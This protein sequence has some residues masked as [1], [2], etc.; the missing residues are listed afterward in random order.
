MTL[1]TRKFS[2]TFYHHYTVAR[3][4]EPAERDAVVIYVFI[5]SFELVRSNRPMT[6]TLHMNVTICNK[7]YTCIKTTCT[8]KNRTYLRIVWETYE[9][10]EMCAQMVNVKKRALCVV[11]RSAYPRSAGV[12][13]SSTVLIWPMKATVV[14]VVSC[15]LS[16]SFEAGTVKFAGNTVWSVP[17][18]FW[19]GVSRRGAI[20]SVRTF[21]FTFSPLLPV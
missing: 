13:V 9:C 2:P 1:T 8:F 20:S 11:T 17:E 10:R 16:R 18:R 19:G 12:T 3:K 5:H 15:L 21:T 6:C 4:N 7:N 14:M